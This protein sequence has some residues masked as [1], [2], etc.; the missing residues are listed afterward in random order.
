MHACSVCCCTVVPFTF[1]ASKF[2]VKST[3]S[4]A[5]SMSQALRGSKRLGVIERQERTQPRPTESCPDSSMT[6][7]LE[8]L[9]I[10]SADVPATPKVSTLV[11]PIAPPLGSAAAANGNRTHCRIQDLSRPVSAQQ[12]TDLF[13]LADV[14][15]T[16]SDEGS[17]ANYSPV[18]QTSMR[19]GEIS[20]SGAG[21]YFGSIQGAGAYEQPKRRSITPGTVTSF[22]RPRSVSL[23]SLAGGQKNSSEMAPRSLSIKVPRHASE[24]C[25]NFSE[26]LP[27]FCAIGK[28]KGRE[29]LRTPLAAKALLILSTQVSSSSST[30]EECSK[31][32]EGSIDE[33]V[34]NIQRDGGIDDGKTLLAA[35]D[36]KDQARRRRMRMRGTRVRAPKRKVKPEAAKPSQAKRRCRGQRHNTLRRGSKISK[37]KTLTASSSNLPASAASLGPKKS[38]KAVKSRCSRQKSASGRDLGSITNALAG[39]V[40]TLKSK[41]NGSSPDGAAGI[42]SRRDFSIKPIHMDECNRN[43]IC[44]GSCVEL[45]DGPFR[46]PTMRSSWKGG[47][48]PLGSEEPERK[49]SPSA[50]EVDVQ[51]PMLQQAEYTELSAAEHGGVQVS[52]PPASSLH[53]QVKKTKLDKMLRQATSLLA[54]T[55]KRKKPVR[56]VKWIPDEDEQL[57]KMVELHRG[58]HW[59]AIAMGM[60]NRSAAQC[61]QR[62]A[63]LN[64]LNRA[65][66]SWSKAEDK[67]LKEYVKK[68]GA[69]NWSKVAASMATRNAKQCRERWHN[70]LSPNISKKDWSQEEDSIIIAMQEKLGNRWAEI[71]RLLPGRTDNAVKNRWHSSIKLKKTTVAA[72]RNDD[73]QTMH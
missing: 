36:E 58:R 54:K 42:A 10:M 22:T 9:A 16:Q 57:R 11:P 3:T 71:S 61:R 41:L 39:Y 44:A 64:S 29:S 70:Q 63:G 23:M 1:R 48:L 68:Y 55:T 15:R 56:R 37:H 72:K 5:T 24:A 47:P 43:S 62:W 60:S 50:L 46:T 12:G 34:E 7:A 73:S 59:K 18:N 8:L 28:R 32:S 45:A 6:T 30:S 65:K 33:D 66:R 67:Q 38:R 51:T 35:S 14:E 26:Q 69:T 20:P 17:R 52:S 21:S 19:S 49:P 31:V 4:S 25:S 27:L 40:S 2:Y 13:Q 53:L